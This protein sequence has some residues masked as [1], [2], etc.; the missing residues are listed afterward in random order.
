VYGVGGTSRDLLECIEAINEDRRQWNVLGFIDDNPTL[1]GTAVFEYPVLGPAAIL[2]Q[3]TYRHCRIAIGV[4]NDKSLFVRRK[5]RDA[6][7]LLPD[8]NA[9]RLPV[10]IHPSAVVSRRSRLGAGSVM[11]SGSFCSGNCS[12]GMH[13]LVLQGSAISHDSWLG[14]CV[15][16]CADVAMGGAVHIGD[17]AFV[18]LGATVYPNVRIG[19]ASRIGMGSV[20]LHHVADGDT[21]SGSPAQRHGHRSGEELADVYRSL[22][23]GV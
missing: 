2:G 4:A 20:V 18:G 14:D 6:L 3:P 9:E 15:T 17:G 22:M 7:Y 12:I 5:I 13:T 23:T 10:I 11:F 8:M 19:Q 16:L 1:A 21:V